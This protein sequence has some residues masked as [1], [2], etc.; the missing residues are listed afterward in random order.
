MH[1]FECQLPAPPCFAEAGI[2]AEE[3]RAL[4]IRA[5]AVMEAG[6]SVEVLGRYTLTDAERDSQVGVLHR[7]AQAPAVLRVGSIA[8]IS[9]RRTLQL[10]VKRFCVHRA[11]CCWL[12][13]PRRS[14][15]PYLR[16]PTRM[17]LAEHAF[18]LR[19]VRL[20]GCADSG[21]LSEL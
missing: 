1:S 12:C 18:L 21:L 19:P 3:Y 4:F 20:P 6:P 11:H 14:P 17:L 7:Q 9:T 10:A 8:V 13:L 5:P 16:P 15:G 2:P